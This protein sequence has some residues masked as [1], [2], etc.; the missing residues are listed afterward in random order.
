MKKIIKLFFTSLVL[1]LVGICCI[2][3]SSCTAE[4]TVQH[5]LLQDTGNFK[6]Y[7]KITIINLRSDKVLMEFEGYLTT[8]LDSEGD[9]NIMI[10]TAP[11]T[12]QLH[13][14]RLADEVTYLSEQ[15][16]NTYTD[17]YHWRIS[18]YAIIPDLNNPE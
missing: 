9:V 11:D 7:R 2:S 10:K 6:T 3:L 12:Y 17:P 15:L 16:D 1:L 18:I 13:Y 14:V 4:N 5:N 8:K